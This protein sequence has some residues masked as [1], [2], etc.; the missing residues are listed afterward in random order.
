MILE[1]IIIAFL[2]GVLVTQNILSGQKHYR[3]GFSTD[4]GKLGELIPFQEQ[5]FINPL[6]PTSDYSA[7]KMEWNDDE[8]RYTGPP[9]AD[10][11]DNWDKLL[12]S[13]VCMRCYSC[14]QPTRFVFSQ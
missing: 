2:L 10:M 8:P 3:R 12:S 13:K 5:A 9:N 7:L 6:R 4:F 11:D 1:A 14:S